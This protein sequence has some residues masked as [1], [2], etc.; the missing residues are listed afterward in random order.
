MEK[1]VVKDIAISNEEM[2]EKL[3]EFLS[4]KSIK[5]GLR[6]EDYAKLQR[7]QSALEREVPTSDPTPS[8]PTSPPRKKR[9]KENYTKLQRF[10]SPLEKEVSTSDPTSSPPTSPP[11]KKRRKKK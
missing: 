9:K 4:R 2:K 1:S 11:R 10:Q 6:K 8:P 5:K 7:F 3:S